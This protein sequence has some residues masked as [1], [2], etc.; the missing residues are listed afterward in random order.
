MKKWYIFLLAVSL[1]IG[2]NAC[3]D[4][5]VTI[6]ITFDTGNQQVLDNVI[7]HPGDTFVL[8]NEMNKEGYQFE[9]WYLDFGATTPYS[10]SYLLNFDGNELTLYAKWSVKSYKIDYETNG[11]SLI[12]SEF[13]EYQQQVVLPNDPIKQGYEF[14]GWYKEEELINPYTPTLMLAESLILYAKWGSLINYFYFDQQLSEQNEI[15]LDLRL[16]G[17][18]STIGYQLIIHYD[19]ASLSFVDDQDLRGHIINFESDGMIYMNYVSVMNPIDEDTLL[20]SLHFNRLNLNS[21]TLFIEVREVIDLTQT[22]EVIHV[23]YN[24]SSIVI[25]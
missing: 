17:E 7:Y 8:P 25:E 3:K 1:I 9:G 2:L 20:V 19:D 16:G 13:V 21:T 5:E 24:P 18:V 4:K 12:N 10:E 14:L 23:D 15:L 11:G 22:Y 6:T